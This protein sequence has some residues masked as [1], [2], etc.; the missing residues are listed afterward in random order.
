MARIKN[1]G[2]RLKLHIDENRWLTTNPEGT[3]VFEFKGEWSEE[4]KTFYKELIGWLFL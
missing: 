2:N 4:D 3:R 1:L